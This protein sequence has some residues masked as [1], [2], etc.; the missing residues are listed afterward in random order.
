MF[1]GAHG[2]VVEGVLCP[3][4]AS[5]GDADDGS[6]IEGTKADNW[7]LE[8]PARWNGTCTGFEVT[9]CKTSQSELLP[10]LNIS[11]VNKIVLFRNLKR[12]RKGNILHGN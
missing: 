3:K 2:I 11:I 8:P 6:G 4:E 1:Q 10:N 7:V 12:S 9:Q 5:H